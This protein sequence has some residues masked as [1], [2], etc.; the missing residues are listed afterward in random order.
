MGRESWRNYKM[1]MQEFQTLLQEKTDAIEQ[2]LKQYLPEEKGYQK[3]VL[4]AMNY[5]LLAGGKRLRPMLMQETFQMFGGRGKCV[6]PFM[7]AIEMIHTYSLVHDDLPAMDNDEYRRGKKTTW[8]VYGNAMGI[9]AGDGLLNYAFETALQAFSLQEDLS[10]M[11]AESLHLT[12]GNM[13]AVARALQVLGQKAGVYGMIGG[14][15]ADIEAEKA[16]TL[17]TEQLLFIH[18]HKTA[19]LI[20]AS[21]MVGAILAGADETDVRAMEKCAY[22]IGIAFQI[23]DDILDVTGDS[24]ELG[25][26]VGSDAQN[27]KITYVTLKG[28]EQSK[29]D[30][31]RLSK[32]AITILNGISGEHAFLEQLILT[33]IHRRK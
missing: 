22:N 18:E 10:E 27:Q 19:A 23:Q 1:D 9:L 24:K 31:E 8:K 28:L 21:V 17:A 32:E 12:V 6:E 5:S 4:E 26:T 33:L 16:D 30:V 25:K 2:I 7:A 15:T 14:Q 20:Q 29:M 11:T 3:T 13:Q